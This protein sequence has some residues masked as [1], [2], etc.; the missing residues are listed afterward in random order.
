MF[1]F[2]LQYLYVVVVVVVG[3]AGIVVVVGRAGK[4]PGRG[5]GD[6]FMS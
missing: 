6:Y 2:I 5:G 3:R 1:H 4:W